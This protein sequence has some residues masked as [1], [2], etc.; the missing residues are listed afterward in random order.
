MDITKLQDNIPADIY[1]QIQGVAD[2]FS[3][4]SNERLAHFLGQCNH[5]SGGFTVFLENLNYSGSA[6]WALFH[7]HFE[8]SAEA[9]TFARQPERIAN[10]IYASRM[11]NSDED[12][13]DGWRYRGKGCIQLTGKSNH[14]AFFSTMDLDSNTDPM[15]ICT[16]YPL[17]SAAWFWNQHNL[18][19]VADNGIDTA[20][21]TTITKKINGGT[22][23]LDDRAAKTNSYFAL[24]SN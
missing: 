14:D 18:N 13:G 9:E 23:G 1:S 8:T 11:G 12:S 15:L 16:N 6:L 4:N 24:L 10:R 19:N 3:I 20:T 5:E 7:T 17:L 22:L 21:I 2:T